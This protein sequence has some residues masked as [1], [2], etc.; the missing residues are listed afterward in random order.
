[1]LSAQNL[2]APKIDPQLKQQYFH[3]TREQN[4]ALGLNP[5]SAQ[6]YRKESETNFK[7]LIDPERPFGASDKQKD[8]DE[9]KIT[10]VSN[11][12]AEIEKKTEDIRLGRQEVT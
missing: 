8:D 9:P 6:D 12:Q 11:I 7:A 3:R 5:D 2:C 4:V 10:G 1:M